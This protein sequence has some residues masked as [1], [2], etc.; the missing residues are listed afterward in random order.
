MSTV[1]ACPL[2]VDSTTSARRLHVVGGASTG[3]PEPGQEA[4]AEWV[5]RRGSR[6][7]GRALEAIGHAVEYLVD[8]RLF[9]VGDHNRRAEQEA[10]QILMRL[11]R[12]VF[13]ECPE[14]VSLR[15]RLKRWLVQRV[16]HDSKVA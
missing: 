8:S 12:A 7:Q 14:V 6:E 13:A 1:A 2:E 11:S 5:Y 9:Q 3:A 10:V 16:M 4:Q 15:K